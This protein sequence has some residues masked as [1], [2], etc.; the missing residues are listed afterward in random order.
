MTTGFSR[1]SVAGSSAVWDAE[2]AAPST[3]GGNGS[4]ESL[5]R[6]ESRSTRNEIDTSSSRRGWHRV[7]GL[8]EF[9]EA[10]GAQYGDSGEIVE[11]YG[12][13]E[14]AH[15]AVRNGVGVTEQAYDVLLVTGEDR[16]AYVDNVLSNAVPDKPGQGCY[17]LLLEPNGRVRLDTYVYT[18]ED[19]L[20]VFLPPGHVAGLVEEWREKV[21]IQ[22]VTFEVATADYAV[23][24]VHGPQS[25][26][27]LASVLGGT[28]VP[29][30]R[31]AFVQASLDDAG[32]TVI[33][34]DRLAGEESYEVVCADYDA[35]VV[36]DMLVN[37]GLNAVPF[38]RRTWE[39]LTLEAGTPLLEPDFIDELPNVFGLRSALDFEKGCYVGQEVVSRIENRG[40]PNA[41]LAGV[42]LEKVPEPGA[43]LRYEGE[44]IGRVTRAAMSP[45]LDRPIGFASI[46]Y[47][48]ADASLEVA[49]DGDWLS[50]ELTT[51]PFLSGS[52]RSA[53]LPEYADD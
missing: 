4:L 46:P 15:L 33:P 26:E 44:Q 5:I 2:G 20:L 42:L 52:A 41:R 18:A 23:I 7:S 9:H 38:G 10:H 43:A 25:T 19:R 17:A 53:R 3:A 49:H 13:P 31:F 1:D 21:F 22:D 11:H 36:M 35:S 24:G 50:A 32:V 27:K 12:R 16:V 47:E 30:A 37:R 8:S 40:Q 6:R 51:L 45:S 34:T 28:A 29:E 48:H 14:R 39:T